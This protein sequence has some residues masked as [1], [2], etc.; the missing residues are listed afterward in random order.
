M[1][2]HRGLLRLHNSFARV[3]HA[4]FAWYYAPLLQCS[5][6]VLSVTGRCDLRIEGICAVGSLYLRSRDH[7]RIEIAVLPGGEL[8]IGD[9]VFIN[10]GARVVAGVLVSIGDNVHIGD[11]AI[12][13][14]SDFHSVDGSSPVGAPIHLEENV[15]IAS[16][17][18]VL[19][20]VTIGRGSVVGA[21][22]VVTR[23][24]PPHSFAAGAPA[25]V[26]RSLSITGEQ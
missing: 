7:N 24:I 6:R 13:L 17:A 23:S 12:I 1:I 22:S 18:I 14:D 25:R 3:R 4:F 5:R 19:K 16:R 10:Q 9:G 2:L 20:G 11:D 21:G 26:I 15:W 8:T